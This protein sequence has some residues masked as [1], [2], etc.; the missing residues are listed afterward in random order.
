MPAP[1]H[2]QL[3]ALIQQETDMFEALVQA[4]N[5]AYVVHR[6]WRELVLE[7]QRLREEIYGWQRLADGIGDALRPTDSG[8]NTGPFGSRVVVY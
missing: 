6:A 8:L 1:T 5:D 4:S 7:N 3:K 2:D